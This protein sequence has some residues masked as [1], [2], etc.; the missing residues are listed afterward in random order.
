MAINHS[1][2]STG[3]MRVLARTIRKSYVEPTAEEADQLLEADNMLPKSQK[4]TTPAAKNDKAAA[5]PKAAPKPRKTPRTKATPRAKAP[6]K[7]KSAPKAQGE[8]VTE[9]SVEPKT[10]AFSEV[11]SPQVMALLKKEID[12]QK[13]DLRKRKAE[14][15][16]KD[17]IGSSASKRQKRTTTVAPEG[18]SKDASAPLDPATDSPSA[19]ATS[20]QDTTSP[21]AETLPTEP[22]AIEVPSGDEIVVTPRRRT[23]DDADSNQQAETRNDSAAEPAVGSDPTSTS[24][25]E[26]TVEAPGADS[27]FGVNVAVPNAVGYLQQDRNT[28]APEDVRSMLPRAESNIDMDAGE[29]GSIDSGPLSPALSVSVLHEKGLDRSAALVAASRQSVA[30]PDKALPSSPGLEL[31]TPVRP[32]RKQKTQTQLPTPPSTIGPAKAG[33]RAL[34]ARKSIGVTEKPS[35]EDEDDPAFQATT[36]DSPE[37]PE[38]PPDADDNGSASDSEDFEPVAKRKPARKNV[39]KEPAT[40]K[41]ATGRVTKPAAPRKTQ[42][43]STTTPRPPKQTPTPAKENGKAPRKPARGK[44]VP[45][46]TESL[47]VRLPIPSARR[48]GRFSAT[49]TWLDVAVDP[50]LLSVS[51]KLMHRETLHEKPMAGGVPRVWAESRQA[52]CET[53]PYFKKPQ[54]GC[55]SNDGHV[56]GFLFDGMGHCREYLDGDVIICRAGGSMEVESSGGMAQKQ[57]QSLSHS[58]PK[59]ILNDIKHQN[60]LI[61]ICGNRNEAAPVKMPHQYCVLGWY[62]PTMVWSEKTRGSK[63][64]IWMTVKYRLE[65]LN[66]KKPAWFSPVATIESQLQA[67]ALPATVSAS[68]E[69]SCLSCQQ[70]YHQ[71]YLR[72]WIC[73]NADC[74]QFWKWNGVDVPYG[75]EGLEYHPAFL[76]HESGLWK[77]EDDS[78]EPEPCDLR[79][80]VPDVGNIIGDNIR[81]VNT[82]GICCPKCGRCSPRRFFKGWVCENSAC[83]FRLFPQHRPVA[84]HMLHTPWD[85]APTLLRN[86]AATL[87]PEKGTRGVNI[88]IK[89]A[90]GYK[91][92]TYTFDGIDGCFVHAAA[93]QPVLREEGTGPDA[94]FAAIQQVDMGLER[95]VF[96]VKKNSKG[97]D[98]LKNAAQVKKAAVS[99]LPTPPGDD[100][101]EE[102]DE[103]VAGPTNGEAY[104]FEDGDL[105]TAF[106]MN[107]GMPYKFVA[108]G[109]S[110]PFSEA[111]WPVIECRRRLNWA[112]RAFLE[113][114]AHEDLN[115]ELIFTYFEGQ[116][117]EY[118][119]D[120]EEGLGPRI[121]T[122]S[123]GG[124][125]KMHLRMKQKHFNGCSKTGIFTEEEPL[126]GGVFGPDMDAK[127]HA[128]WEEL[129]QLKSNGP[130][131]TKRR[132]ELPKELGLVG[133]GS[134]KV[135]PDLVTVTLSHGDII[136]MEGY[137]IQRYLEHKVVPAD[138]LR[139]ALTCRTVLEGHLKEHEKPEYAVEVDPVVYEGPKL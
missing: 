118:H 107:Y 61:V 47:L 54:G 123:L 45:K 4:K 35:V 44:A 21:D 5:K 23:T 100:E 86:G 111:P 31:S 19:P 81:R 33:G 30:M 138:C 130:A 88:S 90:S 77:S 26:A 103:E 137:D 139:F 98:A 108:T 34:R 40:D 131:Y 110:K 92:A 136:L 41:T 120:G 64:N 62:K 135:A 87:E 29:N 48:Q 27:R 124:R 132:K 55:Y 126:A 66:R 71:V 85:N 119:D 12:L 16:L 97:Q 15:E 115:E 91:I 11:V 57:D 89:Y 59:S 38:T 76:L 20:D 7:A 13:I 69:A 67:A 99:A 122:L 101:P 17:S 8:I 68:T 50:T 63:N 106:S 60:P 129:Q 133:K 2:Y 37:T 3:S 65:R 58:Q 80:P 83:D 117:I 52:L 82:R 113:K 114:D 14:D 51:K 32:A 28:P 39:R 36:P 49:S 18:S 56:Y 112:Q 1:D 134:Q 125:A 78:E 22:S 128:A 70:T 96:A 79:P 95:R 25:L 6:T 94:M 84:P 121:A 53:L 10:P 74:D 46:Q 116:K 9:S 93:T 42:R 127:R 102:A 73:L 109:A 43:K 104:V 105:M 24:T 72:G 75:K